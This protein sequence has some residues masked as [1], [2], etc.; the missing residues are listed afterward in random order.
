MSQRQIEIL[1]EN[2][3]VD[4]LIFLLNQ[5]RETARTFKHWHLVETIDSLI[6]RLEK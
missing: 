5:Q 6:E 3:E 4:L 1:L 2:D